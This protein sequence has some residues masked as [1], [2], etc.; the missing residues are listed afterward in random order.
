MGK[1]QFLGQAAEHYAENFLKSRGLI[2]VE[3]NYRNRYGEI[4]LI[5]KDKQYLVFIEVRLRN[6]PM[7]SGS[8]SVSFFKQQ[9]I[10]RAAEYYLKKHQLSHSQY[11]RFDVM[12]LQQ[13]PDGFT[14][15]WIR[16]AFDLSG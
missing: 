15:R 13:Q 1:T 12:G 8:E 2:L 10:I 16:N 5:M 7:V 14:C 9:K 4:D 3:K 11:C 6:N